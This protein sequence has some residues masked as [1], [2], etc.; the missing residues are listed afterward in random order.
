MSEYV[1]EACCP[2]CGA[3]SRRSFY[4]LHGVPVNSVLL[5]PTREAALK[6]PTG[7]LRLSFCDAC[8]LI[9]N[10]AFDQRL[11]EYS[12]R[13]EETQGYSPAFRKWHESLARR[14]V[15]DYKLRGKT[16]LEIGCGK[17][18]FL[19]LLCQ[20]G[21]NRG[22]GFDPTYVP[23]R[24]PGGRA[25]EVKFVRDN[26]SERHAGHRA[27]FVCCKMTL[28]HIGEARDFVGMVRRSLDGAEATPVFFQ[29]PD[30]LRVL[31]D[32]AFWDIYYEHCSYYSAGSLAKLFRRCGFDVARVA[33]EY[34]SQYLTIEAYPREPSG[35]VESPAEDDLHE[36]SDLVESFGVKMLSHVN[37]WKSRLDDYRRRNRRV[38]VWGSGSK[39]VAF[40]TVV[41]DYAR[42]I[43]Y[44]V[45]INP[46]RWDNYMAGAGQKIVGPEYLK[47][48][49]PDVVIVMN[50]IYREE[51]CAELH[52]QSLE[53]EVIT[54]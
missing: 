43:E 31:R 19:E 16:I 14:L 25:S 22:L 49:R 17:G 40:L 3:A 2:G 36:L 51:I 1:S 52:R 5:L 47:S 6:F 42:T 7:D 11:V 12:E 45:D 23:E 29:V 24:A 15:D 50:P 48:Y 20:L 35:R 10:R 18:E 8:G 26:Y 44:V 27:D 37:A 32:N 21:G 41:G 34:D 4:N 39:G 30:V 13:Y 9:W 28:E 33:R 46:N 38:V 53:V 54:T